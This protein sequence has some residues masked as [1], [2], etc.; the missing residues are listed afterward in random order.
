MVLKL[1]SGL[2]KIKKN[3]INQE[4][5]KGKQRYKIKKLVEYKIV[6]HDSD[7]LGSDRI[8]TKYIWKYV[9]KK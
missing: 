4:Y 6:E 7:N 2:I 8:D 1:K 5:Q 9:G 3:N